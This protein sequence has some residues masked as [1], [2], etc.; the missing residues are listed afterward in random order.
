[1][2]GTQTVRNFQHYVYVEL[3]QNARNAVHVCYI[4]VTSSHQRQAEPAQELRP[5]PDYR[6]TTSTSKPNANSGYM[7]VL[8][9]IRGGWESLFGDGNGLM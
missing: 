6:N 7:E 3:V 9:G 4:L 8:E 2:Q 5:T 1:M